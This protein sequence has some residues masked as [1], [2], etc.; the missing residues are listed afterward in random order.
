[1]Y[2]ARE[3]IPYGSPASADLLNALDRRLQEGVLEP[4]A[5]APVARL[6]GVGDIVVRNDLQ[7]ERYN[8]AR[9]RAIYQ[10]L[11][12]PPPGLENPTGFGR[13]KRNAPERFPM[14]DEVALGLPSRAPDPQA[15]EVYPVRGALPIV[16]AEPA[17][18]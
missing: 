8:L 11:T 3:L 15:V 5:I 12:P 10:L 2:V 4:E 6:M 13:T 16:R 17:T 18:R 1:P 9:P 14:L 7:F